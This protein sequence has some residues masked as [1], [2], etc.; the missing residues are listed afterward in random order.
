LEFEVTLT[1]V[2]VINSAR[3]YFY[4][5][6]NIKFDEM[7]SK[8]ERFTYEDGEDVIVKG[9]KLCFLNDKNQIVNIS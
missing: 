4:I 9:W 1:S 5:G 7:I 8:S 2:D 3:F 6:D